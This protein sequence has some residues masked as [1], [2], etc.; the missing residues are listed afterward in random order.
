VGSEIDY[1]KYD[2]SELV[3]MFGRM[4]PR[5]APAECARLARILTERGYIV[6]DGETGPGSAVPSP[7]KLQAL[8]GSSR[9]FACDV[10][11]GKATGTAGWLAPAHN[12]FGFVGSGTLQADGIYV[13]L[14]GRIGPRTS[15]L[16][17]LLPQQVQLSWRQIAD[18]ESEGNLVR[19][20]YDSGDEDSGAI[21]LWLADSS[22]AERLVA[23]LPKVRTKNFR[24]QIKADVEFASRLTTQSPKTPVTVGLV[25]A[26]VLVFIGT[27]FGGAEWFKPIGHV[28]IAW[29]SNFGPYTTDGEW[30]RLLTSLFIHFGIAHVFLN[31]LALVMFGPL[32][33]RLYGS[34]IYLL[35][36]LL[37]GIAGGLASISWHPETNSAGASGAIFGILGA[38]LAAQLRARGTFPIDIL[39]PIRYSTVVFL[40]WALYGGFRYKGIDYAAHLGGLTCGFMTGLAAARPITGE[41]SFSRSDW[42]RLLQMMPVAAAVLALGVWFA[43]NSS[44]TTTGDRLYWR[45]IRW[46]QAGAQ[47]ADGEF[48]AALH[49]VQAGKL[50]ESAFADRVES[51]VL[52]FWREASERISEIDVGPVSPN[53]RALE[54]FQA[55]S[56]SNVHGYE[57]LADGLRKNDPQ[58]KAEAK[59][60]LKRGTALV[61]EWQAIHQ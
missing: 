32:V 13:Y 6:T 50:S 44:A 17:A 60:E 49:L 21:T 41:G 51:D 20:A 48:N 26:N 55:L 1:T 11:F 35:I 18:V 28:Q 15:L 4:D 2:E 42:R 12:S 57:L 33:E 19:F 8:T 43:Q 59:I 45:T 34:V 39:R 52:P 10:D 25:L 37:S 58:E 3:E 7:L 30:W 47:S 40:G 23:I 24:P 46:F 5:Y 31:M 36:Y 61:N 29:G 38:L 22:A 27:L 14:S 53:L 9:L 16:R 56:D 54:L